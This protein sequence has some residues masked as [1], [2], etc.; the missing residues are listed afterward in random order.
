[1]ARDLGSGHATC[2]R[3]PGDSIDGAR[4][5]HPEPAAR[6]SAA[7]L[8]TAPTPSVSCRRVRSATAPCAPSR[9]S[10]TSRRV[11]S[12]S[13]S[14]Q[15]AVGLGAPKAK[16]GPSQASSCRICRLIAPLWAKKTVRN[17]PLRPICSRRFASPT[18]SWAQRLR[19]PTARHKGPGLRELGRQGA[20]VDPQRNGQD[21]I[22]MSG[23]DPQGGLLQKTPGR[24]KFSGPPRGAGW[25][26]SSPRSAL[27]PPGTP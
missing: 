24:P 7:R 18:A 21:G 9:P 23:V 11:S 22:P 12:R 8:Q 10:P 13:V 19:D 15:E 16:I 3:P 6:A 25:A 17:E 20:S 2:Q 4:S 1:M 27:S 5:C 14:T 26:P